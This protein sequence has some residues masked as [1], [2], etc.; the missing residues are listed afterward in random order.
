MFIRK[1]K[2]LDILFAAVYNSLMER[3]IYDLMSPNPKKIDEFKSA[4]DNLLNS[5]YILA[6]GRISLVL[7]AI[8][9][10]Q[11]LYNLFDE[12]LKGFD[13]KATAKEHSTGREFRLP[14]TPEK[15]A[16]L[17]FCVL[18][19]MDKRV[20]LLED[21]LPFFYASDLNVAYEN[22]LARIILP[23]RT[24]VLHLLTEREKRFYPAAAVRTEKTEYTHQ[25]HFDKLMGTLLMRIQ[26]DPSLDDIVKD[27]LATLGGELIIAQKEGNTR[28][29]E[30]TYYKLCK[31]IKMHKPSLLPELEKAGIV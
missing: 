14:D 12:V 8:A 7:E 29:V 30:R 1:P 27:D 25:M 21:F 13:Y 24:A 16:A 28:I 3:T 6:E 23:F 15:I 4:C 22:F 26:S 18:L 20:I 10:S 17:I 2:T 19:D 5:Q 11:T 31:K 9:S